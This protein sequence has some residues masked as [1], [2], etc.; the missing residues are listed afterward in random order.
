ME[1]LFGFSEHPKS[2][3]ES[4]DK[5]A[6]DFDR[7]FDTFRPDVSAQAVEAQEL[8]DFSPLSS[9]DTCP[10]TARNEAI[11]CAVWSLGSLIGTTVAHEIAHSLGL[12]D[13]GGSDFHNGDDFPSALMDQG[14]HRSFTER[15]EI[16]GHSPGAFCA[17]NYAYLTDILPSLD[18]DPQASREECF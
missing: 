10:A 2:L 17:H 14:S 12:A 5:P 13:P 8:V 9:G 16:R 6:A 11:A 7:L 4:L 3:A 15:A 1:S 18:P